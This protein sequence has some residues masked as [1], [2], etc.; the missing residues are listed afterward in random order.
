MRAAANN[1]LRHA[2]R[3]VTSKMERSTRAEHTIRRLPV[4]LIG[5]LV[6]A[7]IA[8]A[9]APS[10]G[11]SEASAEEATENDTADAADDTDDDADDDAA[12]D[13]DLTLDE[14]IEAAQEEGEL[15]VYNTSSAIEDACASFEEEYDITCHGHNLDNPT[16]MERVTREVDSGNVEVSTV[17]MADAAVLSSELAPQGYVENWVP[18]WF[19]DEIPEEYRDP[20]TWRVAAIVIGYNQESY[21]DGCPISNIWEL[22]EDEWAGNFALR[23]PLTT[24]RQTDWF[25]ALMENPTALEEAYEAHFGESL[26]TELDNAAY[27]FIAQIAAG[28]PIVHA[29]DGDVGDAVG[30]PGQDD[31]P[32]GL[33]YLGKHRDNE[34]GLQLALCE[35]LEPFEGYDEMT[36]ASLVPDGPNPNA[37]KLWIHHLLTEAGMGAWTE[38][39][40]G[41]RSSRA[42]LA[43]HP[44]DPY[45]TLD[46]FQDATM[47]IA[48]V[49]L[50]HVLSVRQ[51]VQD[52][53]R[54][55]LA[56]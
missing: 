36:Q 52:F 48:D 54:E 4:S 46:E 38:N 49:D 51:E 28:D 30:A 14:L 39:R 55:H 16:Q 19:E 56:N 34:E 29:S 24:P 37:A 50:D 5:L 26:D 45:Q 15:T 35:D 44:D 13:D 1:P 27:E 11:G 40:F 7:L 12:A 8:G 31:A 32:I 47:T 23:D 17:Q 20:L 22:T 41:D 6:L 21:P 53:W 9:C 25:T 2:T 43:P 42:E 33:Y 10:S 3:G 18:P